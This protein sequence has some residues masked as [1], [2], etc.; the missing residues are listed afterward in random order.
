MGKFA[1]GGI[2]FALLVKAF[3]YSG[4]VPQQPPAM[5]TPFLM[6]S[7]TSSANSSGKMSKTVLPFTLLGRPAFG[8]KSTG[9][10]AYFTYSSIIGSKAF[11]PNEQFV[12]MASAC[13]PSKSATIAAGEAPVISLPSSLYA[14]ETK[15]GSFEFSFAAKRA[16]FV[17]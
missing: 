7:V 5:R 16:A 11:G 3:I 12:P 15:T 1:T 8:F 17:S 2:F 6:A 14:F 10:E 9:T 4:V 13:I